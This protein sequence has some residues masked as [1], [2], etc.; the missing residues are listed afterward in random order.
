MFI[1]KYWLPLSVF[2]VAIAGVGLYLLSIQPPPEPIIIYKAVEPLEKPTEQPQTEMP[3]VEKTEQP[4]QGGHTHADGTWH[5]GAHDAPVEPPSRIES[6]TPAGTSPTGES[7]TGLTYHAKLLASNPAAALREQSKERGHWSGDYLPDFPPD[8]TEAMAIARAEY[9]QHYYGDTPEGRTA[10]ATVNRLIRAM[11]ER[12][13]VN[14]YGFSYA[15]FD[16]R[17]R[18]SDL[19]MLT[20]PSLDYSSERIEN[21]RDGSYPSLLVWSNIYP[22][23]PKLGENR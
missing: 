4:Q 21:Y 18:R 11:Q 5:A 15:D 14:L 6:D 23:L 17:A 16:V 10:A 8:D 3:V 22:H 12:Y 1:R 19:M 2:I 9:H 7:P 20:W 13:P